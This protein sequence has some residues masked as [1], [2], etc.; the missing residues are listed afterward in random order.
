M[1][2]GVAGTSAEGFV[3]IVFIYLRQPSLGNAVHKRLC[4]SNV[5]QKINFLRSP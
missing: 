4:H 3:G 2:S 5:K 1:T